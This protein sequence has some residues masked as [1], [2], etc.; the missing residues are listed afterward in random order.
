MD[1]IVIFFSDQKNR[2]Y[3]YRVLVAVGLLL[4]GYGYITGEQ[5][6]LWGGVLTSAL[7]IMPTLNTTTKSD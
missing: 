6:T 3:I 4:A 1:K 7:N 2:A 5:L